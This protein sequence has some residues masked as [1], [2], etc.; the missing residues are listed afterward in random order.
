MIPQNDIKVQF[1]KYF[2]SF[3]VIAASILL[4]FTLL[5]MRTI[6]DAFN[7]IISVLSPVIVGLVIAYLLN[8][9]MML[10]DRLI[11]KLFLKLKCKDKLAKKLSRVLGLFLTMTTALA[12]LVFLGY[13]VIPELYKSIAGLVVTL[14]DEITALSERIAATVNDYMGSDTLVKGVSN[15]ISSWIKNDLA[16]LV[17]QWAPMVASGVLGAVGF[18]TDF[19][20]G[21]I[22]CIYFLY[23][24]EYFIGATKKV[25][26]A[27][28]KRKN[29][30]NA[31]FK[32]ARHSH[33]VFG[34]FLSGKLLNSLIVGIINFI[35]MLIFD[36]PYPL[37]ISVI[38]GAT[39]II[40]V[41][42]PFIGAVP[43][44]L[45]IL[46]DSPVKALIFVIIII[47]LQQ[48]DGN[49]IGPKVLGESTG[50]SSFWV[51]FAITVGG[52][53]FGITG[54]I[55]GVPAFAVVYDIIV[56]LVNKSLKK[57]K[58]PIN[59]DYYEDVDQISESVLAE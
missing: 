34:G 43:S 31:I 19:F 35:V 42:G 29:T 58:M 48:I 37:L 4:F 6:I 25:V 50:L 56:E 24:K 28:F 22:I 54:M 7:T 12:V 41:F 33:E 23:R 17:N 36:L 40:P 30:V 45:I 46:L 32:T 27:V 20:I 8:P 38:V 57:K 39:D 9:V 3:L 44:T 15:Y 51:I 5:Y 10:F 14:P 11:G 1:K 55:I 21:F 59:T 47:V 26:C 13:M 2:Y 52:G 53:L 49:I 16:T 18:V